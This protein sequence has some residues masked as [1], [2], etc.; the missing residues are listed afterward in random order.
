MRVFDFDLDQ[1]GTESG[2][3]EEMGDES[4]GGS[5]GDDDGEMEGDS[6]Q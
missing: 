4:T 1:G 3:T 2:G 5:D 6:G